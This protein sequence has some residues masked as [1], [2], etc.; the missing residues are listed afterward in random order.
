MREIDLRQACPC[1]LTRDTSWYLRFAK[2]DELAVLVGPN[3]VD[4]VLEARWVDAAWQAH[5]EPEDAST[6]RIIW[7]RQ[8]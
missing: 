1:T 6:V 4:A 7:R 3:G 2:E 5:A 8:A